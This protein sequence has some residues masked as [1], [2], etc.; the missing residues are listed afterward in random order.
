MLDQGNGT[1]ANIKSVD[2]LP[3]TAS[4]LIESG[5]VSR[6]NAGEPR[7]SAVV[8]VQPVDAETP[9][10]GGGEHGTDHPAT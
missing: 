6:R 2:R 9:E 3:D 8:L 1:C 10:G 5:V 7:H 4:R